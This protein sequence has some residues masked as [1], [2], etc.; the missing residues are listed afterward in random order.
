MSCL[1]RDPTYNIYGIGTSHS[2]T[3]TSLYPAWITTEGTSTPG[4]VLLKSSLTASE[5]KIMPSHSLTSSPRWITSLPVNPSLRRLLLIVTTFL[6]FFISLSFLRYL[7]L[8][9]VICRISTSPERAFL[10]A[11]SFDI[12]VI[13]LTLLLSAPTS[14]I[15][16][17]PSNNLSAFVKW[18]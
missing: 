9:P 13:A 2:L 8:S 5:V 14:E 17:S 6:T 15:L 12:L 7:G 3:A 4:Y 1:S 16:F 11:I 10:K 18:S